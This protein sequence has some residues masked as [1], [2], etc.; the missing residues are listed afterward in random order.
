MLHLMKLG[1]R[2]W[3]FFYEVQKNLLATDFILFLDDP[4]SSIPK[5]VYAFNVN[6]AF[7]PHRLRNFY[8]KKI[9]TDVE[10][11]KRFNSKKICLCTCALLNQSFKKKPESIKKRLKWT[12]NEID[13]FYNDNT[14]PLGH[15]LCTPVS[16]EMFGLYWPSIIS[17]T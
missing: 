9:C 12:W 16:H 2:K 8:V 3:I 4:F 1:I 10:Q 13:E 17:Y 15:S 14:I 7:F 5:Y 11:R 6:W